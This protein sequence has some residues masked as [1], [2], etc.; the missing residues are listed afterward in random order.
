MKKA[1]LALLTPL[2]VFSTV[3]ATGGLSL[4]WPSTTSAQDLQANNDNTGPATPPK[5]YQSFRSE[6][7]KY[8][9]SLSPS[10]LAI[11]KQANAAYASNASADNARTADYF[12]NNADATRANTDHTDSAS[13]GGAQISGNSANPPREV[14]GYVPYWEGNIWDSFRWS[15]LTTVAWFKIVVDYKGDMISSP[16]YDPP[17]DLI[18]KAHA[19][20]VKVALTV[21]SVDTSSV[22][23]LIYSPTDY[24]KAADNIVAQVI[25]SG[26]DGVNVDFEGLAAARRTDFTNF[27]T[28]LTN[29]MHAAKSGSQV[30]VAMP[31]IDW[32]NAYDTTS[33]ASASERLVIMGYD[34]FGS[35]STTAGPV[36]PLF[37]TS[38]RTNYSIDS[39]IA[40][41]LS[42]APANKII[43][44][45]PWYGHKWRTSTT[46][47][48]GSALGSNGYLTYTSAASEAES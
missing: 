13:P 19:H 45:V 42:K 41:Y 14:F 40:T 48:P 38:W 23:T 37:D 9:Q 5:K 3:L 2:F 46:A 28:V 22:N 10:Q 7:D 29:K 21:T 25:S 33:L 20:G 16:D 1:A 47:V 43:L 6:Q 24:T 44:A 18:S 31:A 39:T 11:I 12:S 17:A 26:A 4:I 35:W 34:Y 8:Y 30:S 32:N 36:A 27:V 15:S